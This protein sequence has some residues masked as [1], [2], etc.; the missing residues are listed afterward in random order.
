MTDFNGKKNH[1]HSLSSKLGVC[2][3]RNAPQVVAV[4]PWGEDFTLMPDENLEIVAFGDVAV[5]WFNVVQWD[6]TSQVY[7]E[8]TIDF[9]VFQKGRELKCGHQRQAVS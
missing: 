1:M 4:E 6:G 9:K 2:N 3:G 5:P 7:C 8:D